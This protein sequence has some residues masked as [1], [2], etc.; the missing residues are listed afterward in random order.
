MNPDIDTVYAPN[1]TQEKFDYIKPGIDSAQVISLLGQPL[2]KQKLDNSQCIWYYTGDGKCSF[3][4]Y[5]WL[6]REVYISANGKVA[7][8]VKDIYYD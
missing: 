6:G 7:Q 8:T 4:D 2:G 5:A 1:F 3:G